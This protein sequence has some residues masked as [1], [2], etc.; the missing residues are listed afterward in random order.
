MS[1]WGAVWT[2]AMTDAFGDRPEL[3]AGARLAKRLDDAELEFAPGSVVL[4]TA[5]WTAHLGLRHIDDDGWETIARSLA[6]EP[7]LTSAV[8]VG[9]LPLE[10]HSS[11]EQ[12]G[13]PLAP[14]SSDLG[15]DCSCA[16]WHD[17]CRHVGALI[18]RAAAVVDADPWV[19][20]MLRGRSRGQLVDRIN[21]LRAAER[22]HSVET[23]I[24]EARGA[25][26]GV[27]AAAAF[28]AANAPLPPPLP[29]LRR[30]GAPVAHRPPPIDGGVDAGDLQW[31]VADAAQRAF[32]LLAGDTD[33]DALGLSVD[34]DRRRLRPT[35]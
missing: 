19:L 16:D 17:P 26:P 31:L 32:A 27:S 2:S 13:V 22:G 18:A 7:R 10:L 8:L 12:L 24:G 20:T 3:T 11:L 5:D 4:R 21:E 9:E 25:D 1:W 14:V 34:D 35:E 15:T 29:R 28:R 23:S 6:A 33:A 30:A